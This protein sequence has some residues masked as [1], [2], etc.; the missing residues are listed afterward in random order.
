MRTGLRPRARLVNGMVTGRGRYGVNPPLTMVRGA[1]C[2]RRVYRSGSPEAGKRN[3]PG[4]L[5]VAFR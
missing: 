5:K 2:V 1:P 4:I 3:D